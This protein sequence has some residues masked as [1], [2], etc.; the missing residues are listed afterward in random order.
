MRGHVVKS[1]HVYITLVADKI[2]LVG[3]YKIMD[4]GFYVLSGF[5]GD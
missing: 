5:G 1:V 4:G 3:V 2:T